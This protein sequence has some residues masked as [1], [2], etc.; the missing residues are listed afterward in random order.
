MKYFQQKHCKELVLI[1]MGPETDPEENIETHAA[2]G[3]GDDDVEMHAEEDMDEV[4]E[5]DDDAEEM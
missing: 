1:Q 2:V 4:Q 3:V 5:G